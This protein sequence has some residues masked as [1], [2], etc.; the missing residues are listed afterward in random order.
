M[1]Q[2]D[3]VATCVAPGTQPVLFH[4]P[5]DEVPTYVVVD[6]RG[7]THVTTT[8]LGV[9]VTAVRQVLLETGEA[10]VRGSDD[11]CAHITP[12]RVATDTPER[13]W[14]RTVAASLLEG[15]DQ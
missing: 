2:P 3:Y 8:S 5:G 9:A 15:A 1:N 13:P 12:R 10:W 11:C 7:T 14:I 6:L 4:L